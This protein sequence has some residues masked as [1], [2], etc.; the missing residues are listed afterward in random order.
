AWSR[1]R[2]FPF[3][4]S[5]SAR[6]TGVTPRCRPVSSSRIATAIHSGPRPEVS[7]QHLALVG[8]GNLELFSIFRNR[9]ARELQALALQDADNLRVTQRL[10]RIFLLDDLADALL[11]GDG[12]HRFPV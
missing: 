2:W 1:Q 8:C 9:P 12:G 6:M 11:D 4:S 5:T 3:D 10:P 7:V